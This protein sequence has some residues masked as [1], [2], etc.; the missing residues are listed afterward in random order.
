MMIFL[1]VSYIVKMVVIPLHSLHPCIHQNHVV[2]SVSR[3][4]AHKPIGFHAPFAIRCC[5]GIAI[6][7]I[8]VC[9]YYP[10]ICTWLVYIMA[11]NIFW[12]WI[13]IWIYTH[14]DWLY[15]NI[16]DIHRWENIQKP[17]LQRIF[18]ISNPSSNCQNSYVTKFILK[19]V[20]NSSNG[21]IWLQLLIT[22]QEVFIC[23]VSSVVTCI[24]SF[25][26]YV[27]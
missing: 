24:R 26:A 10:H 3:Y 20:S 16:K 27:I 17:L 19:H 7:D 18:K 6:V 8:D 21:D 14:T 13:W 12:I 22:L 1:P 23:V 25:F 4:G 2:W 9:I 15:M 5:S 11:I